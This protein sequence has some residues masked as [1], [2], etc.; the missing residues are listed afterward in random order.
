MGG[1]EMT[2]IK[3]LFGEKKRHDVDMTSGNI[4]RHLLYFAFPLLLGNVFQQLYNMVDTWV[5]GN[6]VGNTAFSAVG[7]VGPII[8]MLIGF[9]GG[10]ASGAGAVISQYY[11]A[12]Q[13]ERVRDTVHTTILMTLFMALLFTVIGVFITPLM[14]GL[15]NTPEEVLPEATTYLI[16]YFSGVIGLMLYNVGAGILRAVG[17]SKRPF[18]FLLVSALLNTA[19]DLLFVLA[20]GMG[21]EG[22]ALATIIAQGV[23]AILVMITLSRAESC[24]RIEWKRLKMDFG[25]LGKIFK[26]GIPAALQMAITGFSN[27]FVQSYINDFGADGMSGWTAYAKID[28]LILLPM[29][30]LAMASTTFV[31]QNLGSRQEARARAG[32]GRALLLSVGT[33]AFLMLPVMI[34]APQLVAFFNDT[35]R[36]VEYGTLLL[37]WI[38]PFYVLCCVNQILAGALRG[39]GNSHAPMIIM[40]SSFVALRQV[41]L[42]VM[43]D[44]IIPWLQTGMALDENTRLILTAM[45]YPA[46]WLAASVLMF[47]YYH[48]TKLT[49]TRLVESQNDNASIAKT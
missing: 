11:G 2:A 49:S 22:V 19:L 46:G 9:F 47:V 15:M 30:S 45:S 1:D 41:F 35:A 26:V 23:S 17:D 16:V 27:V 48:R 25:I 44:H 32:V 7:S 40:L 20:F 12:K 38:S 5:V 24:V 29:Q 28:Q 18:Y 14:L 6:F 42:Y 34:F 3:G 31:A 21:V 39:A 43:T 10:L 33:T 4:V 36:V 8:N 37:R 13:E